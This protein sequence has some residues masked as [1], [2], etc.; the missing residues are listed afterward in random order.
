MDVVIMERDLTIGIFYQIMTV[1]KY[2]LNHVY[3]GKLFTLDEAKKECKKMKYVI[4]AIG[5][6]WEII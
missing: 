3:P 2:G 1:T 4:H 6:S 5:D